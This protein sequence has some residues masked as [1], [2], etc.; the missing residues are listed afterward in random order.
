M[1]VSR[2]RSEELGRWS[3][4]RVSS[5][6]L[7]PR[8]PPPGLLPGGS[9]RRSAAVFLGRAARPGPGPPSGRDFFVAPPPPAREPERPP[10]KGTSRRHGRRRSRSRSPGRR[11]TR[12]SF[13]L[14]PPRPAGGGGGGRRIG[15]LWPQGSDLDCARGRAILFLWGKSSGPGRASGQMATGPS[16][17]SRRGLGLLGPPPP[18]AL[19]RSRPTPGR[20]VGPG[21]LGRPCWELDVLGARSRL[22]L[23]G[24]GS[25]GTP[26][27]GRALRGRASAAG[28]P[29]GSRRAQSRD[30]GHR[31][32]VRL[33]RVCS[34]ASGRAGPRA[35]CEFSSDRN[36]VI[37]EDGGWGGKSVESR[38]WGGGRWGR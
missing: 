24:P 33:G 32:S 1:P 7:P 30:S 8:R 20:T 22:P 4:G 34:R 26:A 35:C 3:G 17:R 2:V 25:G 15:G 12:S 37:V 21:G 13:A 36:G 11:R 10:N 31:V 16:R 9:R 38:Q 29:S 6:S 27:G 28:G 14:S 19:S 5:R 23:V 18:A